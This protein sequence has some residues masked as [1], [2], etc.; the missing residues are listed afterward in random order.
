MKLAPITTARRAWLAPGD[1]R[2]AVGERAQHVN[3]RPVGAG[4]VKADRL[5][6]GRE[7]QPVERQR[8]ARPRGSPAALRTSMRRDLGA[9]PKLDALLGVEFRAAAAASTLPARCRRDSPSSSSAGRTARA[10]SALIIVTLPAK[11]SRRSI[12]AAAKPAAPPPT[13]TTRSGSAPTRRAASDGRG[14]GGALSPS[15]NLSRT[16]TL[17]SRCSTR[18]H[19]I[20]LNAG[21]ATPRRCAG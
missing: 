10:S 21:A 20:G 4:N 12:S 1:D 15:A 19:G 7:Q 16:N 13:I 5:G 2:A 11:P 9:Q 8:R 14:S 3:V 6:A 18:Q 17:P